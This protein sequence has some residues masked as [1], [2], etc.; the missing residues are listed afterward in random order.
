MK[1]D[2]CNGCELFPVEARLQPIGSLVTISNSSLPDG[3]QMAFKPFSPS[4]RKHLR[5]SLSPNILQ[6]RAS[7]NQQIWG[8]CGVK[9]PPPP[10]K[11]T[12]NWIGRLV[13]LLSW[14]VGGIVMIIIWRGHLLSWHH[15]DH[16]RHHHHHPATHHHH[17]IERA[18]SWSSWYTSWSSSR[19]GVW[20]LG[21]LMRACALY[22]GKAGPAGF[23][24]RL[25]GLL[26]LSSS[27]S[28]SWWQCP[29]KMV[30]M[31]QKYSDWSFWFVWH[32][33]PMILK[34]DFY[35]HSLQMWTAWPWWRWWW[36]RWWKRIAMHAAA[37][38]GVASNLQLG[39]QALS[40]LPT[41]SSSS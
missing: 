18:S 32:L 22:L 37:L 6:Y 1:S 27:L 5:D 31:T 29:A 28:W 3:A 2:Q 19:E 34:I 12:T 20:Y 9:E 30:V 39:I 41:L 7:A 13:G 24:G 10:N 17:H 4:G 40:Q 8:V 38:A 11:N 15:H 14:L 26:R 35:L 36:W 21:I 25:I 16:H 33:F 23:K